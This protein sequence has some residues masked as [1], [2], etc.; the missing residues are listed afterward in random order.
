MERTNVANDPNAKPI[1]L[2]HQAPEGS[3]A[4]YFIE[5]HWHPVVKIGRGA[6]RVRVR[7]F[8]K[9]L[10]TLTL[11]AFGAF[12]G[13]MVMNRRADAVYPLLDGYILSR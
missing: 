8:F 5:G 4:G 11:P 12:K 10:T 3:T 1:S 7:C 2:V 13:G 6:D 9:S